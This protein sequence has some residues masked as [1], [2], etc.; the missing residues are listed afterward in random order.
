MPHK[1]LVID[2]NETIR[3]SLSILLQAKGYQVVLA[4]DG[5]S[6]V[7]A[8]LEQQPDL[9]I[10]DMMMP[11]EPGMS[12]IARIRAAAPD[13]PIIAMS[14]SVEGG[15]KSF[16]QRALAAGATHYLEKPFDARDLLDLVGRTLARDG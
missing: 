2:D 14:G 7:M 11:G 15:L 9:I 1:I 4:V 5:A 16:H 8:M 3:L 10:S 6:G 12:A 13:L